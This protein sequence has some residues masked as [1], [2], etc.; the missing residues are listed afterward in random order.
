MSKSISKEQIKEIESKTGGVLK[1]DFVE[2]SGFSIGVIDSAGED[3]DELKREFEFLEETPKPFKM[4]KFLSKGGKFIGDLSRAQ[5][6]YKNNLRVYEPY[7]HGVA[8]HHGKDWQTDP[9]GYVG[10]THRGATVFK[11]GYRRFDPKY[12]F[13]PKDF[14]EEM[15]SVWKKERES[16]AQEYYEKEGF[17]TPEEYKKANPID[18]FIP[19]IWRGKEKIENMDECIYAALQLSKY[20]S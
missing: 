5:W 15:V 8:S 1:I 7:P 6:F 13:D 17:N 18:D 16:S 12:K 11:I 9:I 10:F 3:P 4:L 19:F 14:P 2:P 20:L